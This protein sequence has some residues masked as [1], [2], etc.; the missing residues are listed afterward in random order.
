ME[1]TQGNCAVCTGEGV[2]EAGV[3]RNCGAGQV[4]PKVPEETSSNASE[5][6]SVE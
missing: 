2:V 4:I 1:T 3:C 5:E 6:K